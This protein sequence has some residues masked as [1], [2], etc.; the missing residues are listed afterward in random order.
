MFEQKSVINKSVNEYNFPETMTFNQA[1]VFLR[2]IGYSFKNE[3]TFIYYREGKKIK[4]FYV[5]ELDTGI[6]FA[7]IKARKDE[8]F[9]KLQNWRYWTEVK[10]KTIEYQF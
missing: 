4:A 1:I 7:N 2:S 6:G 5:V 10:T 3:D 9:K 8:N